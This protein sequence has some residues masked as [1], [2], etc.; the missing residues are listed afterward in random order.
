VTAFLSSSKIC[1]ART[2]SIR[3]IARFYDPAETLYRWV[4]RKEDLRTDHLKELAVTGSARVLE[5]SVGTGPNIPH[6]P[7]DCEV[8]GL[9]ISW[10]MLKRCRKHLAKWKRTAELFLGEAERLP[11][12]DGIFDVVFHVGGINFFNDRARAIAEMIRVAK[13][14]TKVVIVDE[15]EKVVKEIYEKTPFT[16]KYFQKRENAVAS[17]V[18]L[19]PHDMLDIRSKE[20][21]DGRLYCLSFRKP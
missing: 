18:D 12:R 7:S 3:N 2:R 10:R 11:F 17:P 8:F 5:V 14:G 1:P 21:G 16:K 19:V 13:P 6:L 9:D 4:F 15:T 20:I